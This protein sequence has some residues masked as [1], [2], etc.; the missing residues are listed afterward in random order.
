MVQEYFNSNKLQGSDGE[1]HKFV[2]QT[3]TDL[4]QKVVSITIL[5][6]VIDKFCQEGV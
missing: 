4:V 6:L 1:I 5:W 3:T 2:L